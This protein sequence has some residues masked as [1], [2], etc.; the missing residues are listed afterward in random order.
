M[1]VKTGI[2]QFQ[3]ERKRKKA[4]EEIRLK[5]EKERKKLEAEERLSMAKKP[6]FVITKRSDSDKAPGSV[7]YERNS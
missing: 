5:A 1:F 7:S 4:E 3:E 2:S 6:N